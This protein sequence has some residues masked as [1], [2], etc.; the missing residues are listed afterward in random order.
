[1]YKTI[2]P[3]SSYTGINHDK[4]NKAIDNLKSKLSYEWRNIY[5]LLSINDREGKG[6]VSRQD[7]EQCSHQCGAV[8][9]KE[10]TK[11]IMTLCGV[12]ENHLNFQKLSKDLGMHHNSLNFLKTQVQKSELTSKLR[13]LYQSNER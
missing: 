8:I 5:R 13:N 2:G 7:F 9:S 11:K 10:D 6:L 1:M 4:D 3:I 12:N